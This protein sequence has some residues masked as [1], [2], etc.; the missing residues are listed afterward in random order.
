MDSRIDDLESRYAYQ[1]AAV[2]ELTRRV[3]QQQQA[4]DTLTQQIEYMKSLLSEMVPSA[5]APID[6]ETP[7]PHY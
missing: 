4:I 2:E 7:P 6:E 1:E 3:M 5:V